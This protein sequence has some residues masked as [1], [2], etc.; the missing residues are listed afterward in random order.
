MYAE[1]KT[2]DAQDNVLTYTEA[3][4]FAEE[5][6]TTYTYDTYGRL[7]TI[8]V[9]SVVDLQGNKVTSFTY[10]ANDNLLTRTEQGDEEEAGPRVRAVKIGGCF[11]D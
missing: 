11:E 1:E 9:P 2:Y 7:E 5:R 3:V 10:D 8:T 4:S 6:T